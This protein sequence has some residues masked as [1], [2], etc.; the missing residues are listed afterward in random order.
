[1]RRLV[2]LTVLLALAP[3][4]LAVGHAGHGPQVVSIS[5]FSYA[6]A[7]VRLVAGDYL[8]WDWQGP[9]TNHSV[10][11]DAGQAFSFDSDPGG[12]PDHA[13]GDGWSLRFTKAGTWSYHCK[14]HPFMTGTVEVLPAP[15]A[16]AAPAPRLSRVRV[17]VAAK[18]RVLLRYRVSQAASLRA[19]VRRAKGKRVLR[20][21]DFAGPPGAH[22]RKLKLRGLAT[23]RYRL[24][25]VAVDA[26][27]G[28]TTKP[29]QR[30]FRIR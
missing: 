28:R 2:L 20:E 6:P 29:V 11:S 26:S 30:R 16:P 27:N 1:M 14:V 21:F 23:G 5:E 25:L 10:T 19:T 12:A 17:T 4:T 18:R 24:T 22:R 13:V 15:A 3:A 9:D 7:H 8:F